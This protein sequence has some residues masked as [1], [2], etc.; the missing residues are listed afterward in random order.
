MF[1]CCACSWDPSQTTGTAVPTFAHHKAE[2]NR[3]IK[4]AETCAI[5]LPYGG[6]SL[7]RRP[8]VIRIGPL[9]SPLY[10]TLSGK[11]TRRLG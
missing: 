11:E 2:Y 3:K 7:C 6:L 5:I 8:V 1:G 4:C 10:N 9:G